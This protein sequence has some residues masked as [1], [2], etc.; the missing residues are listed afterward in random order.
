MEKAVF[1]GGCFWCLEDFYS[2]VK[3]V[4]SVRSGYTGGRTEN[5]SYQQVCRGDTGHREA[6]LIEYDER[7]VSYRSLVERFFSL[8]DPTDGGG[9]FAD[10]GFQYTTAVYYL[11]GVQRA[12][13][14]MVRY[15]IAAAGIYPDPL[16]TEI[17][18]AGS[19]YP[20][21]QQHQQYSKK[22]PV[23]YSLYKTGSGR[24]AFM[25]KSRKE[26]GRFS[27]IRISEE[28]KKSKLSPLQYEVTQHDGTEPPFENL[29]WRFDEE[30]IYVDIVSG[31]PLFSSKD[32]FFSSCGWPAF[33]NPIAADSVARHRDSRFG[34][35]RTEVRSHAAD[36]HLGHVF[37]EPAGLRY[38]I[39]SAALRFVPRREMAAQGYEKYLSLFDD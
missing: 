11:G 3:G 18:P 1:A 13:A 15:D 4:E 5:P 32:K 38:C 19:F 24:S 6:V 33:S 22:C 12:V 25:E 16:V 29:Y 30:G 39:N 36:A 10:R 21:E 9:Q 28:E 14:E 20:A 31:E 17:L 2:G 27:G 34:M 7:T 37:D 8:I 35:E 26:T 23:P